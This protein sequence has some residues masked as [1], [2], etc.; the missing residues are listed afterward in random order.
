MLARNAT[1]GERHFQPLAGVEIHL[2]NAGDAG[3]E[4]QD[5]APF[6]ELWVRGPMV[7]TAPSAGRAARR[8]ASAEN[9]VERV[10][11]FL[12]S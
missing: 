4:L 8:G 7:M 3:E 11:C 12:V 1:A 9:S 2:G 10:L 5:G 6:G